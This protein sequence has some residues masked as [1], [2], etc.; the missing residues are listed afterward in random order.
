MKVTKWYCDMCG[1]EIKG[2]T[3]AETRYIPIK[4]IVGKHGLHETKIRVLDDAF[5]GSYMDFCDDC[6]KFIA[7]S[8]EFRRDA[9]KLKEELNKI[10]EESNA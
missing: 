6:K 5:G 9:I 3:D 10:M 4:K 7:S 8:F 2:T 1:N